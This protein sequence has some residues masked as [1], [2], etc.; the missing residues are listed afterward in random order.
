[1]VLSTAQQIAAACCIAAVASTAS[2]GQAKSGAASFSSDDWCADSGTACW[3]DGTRQK[4]FNGVR[5]VA[6]LDLSTIFQG[7]DNRFETKVAVI[8][9]VALEFNIYGAWAAAQVGLISPGSVTL[10]EASTAVDRLHQPLREDRRVGVTHG[11]VVG[12]SILDGAI[13]LGEG[14]VHYDRRDFISD[15][16]AT[17]SARKANRKVYRDSFKYVALQSVSS[18]RAAIKGSKNEPLP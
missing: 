18:A 2:F 12:V 10:D 16:Q 3:R 1:M 4:W 14:R 6:E 11:W 5:I 17:D 13:A 15:L 8:P 7:G 9:K